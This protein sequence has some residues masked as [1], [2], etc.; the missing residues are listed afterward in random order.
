MDLSHDE[1]SLLA[2]L[3]EIEGSGDHATPSVIADMICREYATRAPVRLTAAG[4]DMLE[5]LRAKKALR[6][7]GPRP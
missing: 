4:E 3:E 2:Q 1:E 5:E 7:R 6:P